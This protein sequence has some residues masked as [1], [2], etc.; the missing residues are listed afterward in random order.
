MPAALMRRR[1]GLLIAD[2]SWLIA[3]HSEINKRGQATFVNLMNQAVINFTSHE[4][5]S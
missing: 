5:W 2:S 4:L 1:A 3:D